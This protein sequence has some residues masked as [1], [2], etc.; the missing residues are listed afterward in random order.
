VL[1]SLTTRAR[2]LPRRRLIAGCASLAALA[3]ALA[4]FAAP[5]GP[6]GPAGESVAGA[7]SL[8][9]RLPPASWGIAVPTSWFAAPI[10]ALRPGDRVDIVALKAAERPTATAIAF[11]LEV[12]TVDERTLVLGVSAFDATAIATARA[13]GQLIVPLLRSTR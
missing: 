5:A 13:G 1:P 9:A 6:A 12:M 4:G 10:G 2:R 7:A 3:V 8:A 11:D